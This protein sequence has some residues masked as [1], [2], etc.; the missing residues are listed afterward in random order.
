MNTAVRLRDPLYADAL[1]REAGAVLRAASGTPKKLAGFAGVSVELSRRWCAG[2]RSNPIGR[3]LELQCSVPEPFTVAALFQIQALRSLMPL[4]DYQLVDR[5]HALAR[6]AT[7]VSA[8]YVAQQAR[9]SETRSL[10]GLRVACER[11]MA[12]MA[13]LAAVVAEL[14]SPERHIDPWQMRRRSA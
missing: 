4:D 10:T 7:R 11:L 5:Y 12:E 6:E 3:A 1:H 2:E 14:E 13:Q 9:A 8:E